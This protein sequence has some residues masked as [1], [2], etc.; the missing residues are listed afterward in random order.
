MCRAA[1]GTKLC[2]SVHAE[3]NALISAS[4]ERMIGASLYLTGVDARTGGYV[5]KS[6]CCSMCKRMVI[7]AGIEHVYI[8]DTKNEYRKVDVEDWIREDE[9]LEGKFGY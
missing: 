6:S 8:R 5:E 2:R 1:S 3:A 4:R 7:N 9:S